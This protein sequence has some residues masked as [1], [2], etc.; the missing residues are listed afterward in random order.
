MADINYPIANNQEI[1]A[2]RQGK[3]SLGAN[4][5]SIKDELAAY[6]LN[7]ENLIPNHTFSNG[8]VGWTTINS[9]LEINESGN[10][11]ITAAATG[12]DERAVSTAPR[13]QGVQTMV[14]SKV[15]AITSGVNSL[16][17]VID[18]QP[19]II[20]N[21]PRIN[22]WYTITDIRT[23]TT[24]HTIG[25]GGVGFTGSIGSQIEVEY[26]IAIDFNEFIGNGIAKTPTDVMEIID[27]VGVENF[28]GVIKNP[29][30]YV[31]SWLSKKVE[32]AS[33]PT[34]NNLVSDPYF[35][36]DVT[37]WDTLNCNLSKNT[38]GHLIMTATSPGVASMVSLDP[39]TA[40][41]RLCTFAKVRALTESVSD[42]RVNMDG[43]QFVEVVNP[44]VGEWYIIMKVHTNETSR[45]IGVGGVSFSGNENDKIEVEYLATFKVNDYFG[46]EYTPKDE[47]VYALVDVLDPKSLEGVI[48][49]SRTQTLQ[50]HTKVLEKELVAIKDE[51][52]VNPYKKYEIHV[53]DT[54]YSLENIT[55]NQDTFTSIFDDEILATYKEIHDKYGTVFN[56]SLFTRIDANVAHGQ[57]LMPGY[58]VGWTLDR[59]TDKF[60]DEF[61]RNSHWL[62]FSCHAYS[63]DNRRP[64]VQVYRDQREQVLR[65]AGEKSWN[66]LYTK[67]HSYANNHENMVNIRNEGNRVWIAHPWHFSNSSYFMTPEE[68]TELREKGF[69]HY[70]QEDITIIENAGTVERIIGSAGAGPKPNTGMYEYFEKYKGKLNIPFLSVETHENM[71]HGDEQVRTELMETA[72]WMHDNGYKPGFLNED[73]LLNIILSGVRP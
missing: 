25:A 15:R 54:I 68:I 71:V 39:R 61:E 69:V 26:I 10:L 58:E 41:E 59:M 38:S 16:N 44:N 30:Q 34:I 12:G 67:N 63:Y 66:G 51:L 62:K 1:I 18:N 9:G 11:V 55:K 7:M 29:T 32:S 5:T 36:T 48:H 47:E 35:K 37:N 73:D 27:E 24:N 72:R 49:V 19:K 53:D 57:P 13:K 21:N 20:K 33:I 43:K 56:L 4:L 52:R 23:N 3:A 60:K 40:G 45:T 14:I 8:L 31:I 65:F 50:W 70:P 6:N 42:I 2:A 22:E 46:D 17:I 28:S 64:N